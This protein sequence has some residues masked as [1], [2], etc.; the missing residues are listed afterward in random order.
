MLLV[1]G[2]WPAFSVTSL[3]SP[4]ACSSF[5]LNPR[6]FFGL[7]DISNHLLANTAAS[8]CLV[9]RKQIDLQM[10]F[11]C[12][13]ILLLRSPL[14][15]TS[16]VFSAFIQA[17]NALW[18]LLIYSL[19]PCW[20]LLPHL[21]WK[22]Q[23]VSSIYLPLGESPLLFLLFFSHF[24]TFSCNALYWKPDKSI[25]DE[26]GQIWASFNCLGHMADLPDMYQ[27]LSIYMQVSCKERSV[28]KAWG[29]VKSE[30]KK[31]WATWVNACV[32]AIYRRLRCLTK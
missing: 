6:L 20:Y 22:Y 19:L 21:F 15:H 29:V 11:A 1:I 25:P 30:H 9:F 7:L 16:H 13:L 23:S 10:S 32:S 14:D 31:F 12:L 17:A 18:S 26:R 2:N 28:S 5:S 27:L 24:C 8:P 3:L 4:M